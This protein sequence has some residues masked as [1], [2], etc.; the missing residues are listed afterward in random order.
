MDYEISEQAL[1]AVVLCALKGIEGVRALEA[2]PRSLADVFRRGRPVR[3]ESTPE[4]L[5]VDLLLAVPYGV[6]IPEL[7]A[8]VQ[9][10]VDEALF[11]ATGRRARAVNVTVGQ[12]V[13]KEDHAQAG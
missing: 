11:L 9:Q 2:G 8:R 7:A 5:V 4:G 1:E 6:A 10:E 13:P 3:L 12:V